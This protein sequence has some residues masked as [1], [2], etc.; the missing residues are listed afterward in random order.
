MRRAA[1]DAPSGGEPRRS[2]ADILAGADP[3]PPR[4][5]PAPPRHDSARPP[6]A[7]HPPARTPD[8]AVQAST[9]RNGLAPGMLLA[10]ELLL[11]LVLGAALTFGF[12]ILWVAAPY[13]AALAAPLCLCLAIGVLLAVRMRG[14]AP[15][16]PVGQLLLVVFAFVLL[17][18]LPAAWA[19]AR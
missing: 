4:Q 18:S 15:S 9:A 8:P 12:R 1:H 2:V 5:E 10:V 11:M 14:G 7:A 13:A 17:V 16:M 19:L 6:H 3:A